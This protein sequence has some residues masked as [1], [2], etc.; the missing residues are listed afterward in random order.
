[1]DAVCFEKWQRRVEAA[2]G[3]WEQVGWSLGNGWGA[4][5]FMTKRLE[6][7]AEEDGEQ[8]SGSLAMGGSAPPSVFPLLNCWGSHPKPRVEMDLSVAWL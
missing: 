3:T 1:M 4:R 8:C 7:R 6:A 2:G 5:V